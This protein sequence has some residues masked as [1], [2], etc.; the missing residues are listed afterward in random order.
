MFHRLPFSRYSL[1]VTAIYVLAACSACAGQNGDGV[2]A[3]KQSTEQASAGPADPGWPRVFEKDHD[4]VTLYQPQIDEWPNYASISFRAALSVAHGDD[5]KDAKYGV[6]TVKAKTFV[7]HSS[8][9][10]FMTDLDTN[11]HF[12]NVS[13]HEAHRLE[14]MVRKALPKKDYIEVSLERVL[15]CMNENQTKIPHVK[16]N[17]APP[18]IYFSDSPAIMVIFMGPPQFKPVKNTKLMCATNTN[19]DMFLDQN[20]SQYYLL[21]KDSWLVSPDP[22]KGPWAAADNIPSELSQLPDDANWADVIKNIP[23]KYAEHPPKVFTSTKPAELIVTKGTPEYT[24]LSGC[25]LMYVSNPPTPLFLDES[26][27]SYYFLAAGRWFRATSLNGPWAEASTDLPA[28]FAK[29]PADSPVAYVLASVPGTQQAKDAILLASIP[30][31]A[32]VKRGEAKLEVEYDGKPKFADIPDT[33]MKYA[34]NSPEEVILADGKYYCCS[35]GVWFVAADP[36][37]PWAVCVNVPEIIYTIPSTSPVYNVTYVHVYSDTP[38][39]V[40]VGYTD[41]YY[42]EY[43][44][45]TGALMFGAGMIVGAALADDYAYYCPAYFSYGCAA[46]YHYAYGGFYRGCGYYGPYGGAG[47]YAGYNPVT[48][49]FYRGSYRYG[50]RGAASFHQAYNPWTNTYRAHAGATNGYRS[51]GHSAVTRGDEWAKSGHVSG[52]H[53]SAGWARTSTG[54][55]VAGVH[56]AGG[57]WAVKGPQNNVY[58]GHDGNVYK[59]PEGGGWQHWGGDNGWQD[60]HRSAGWNDQGFQNHLN[61]DFQSRSWGND[62]SSRMDQ[63]RGGDFHGFEGGHEGGFGGFGGFRGGGFGGFH[64][65][66]F[67]G[68]HG[69][70]RR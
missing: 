4:R 59:R 19:W 30:H 43:I 39:T 5:E 12:P 10:V 11:V 15:A 41:G 35:K 22:L 24:P 20:T 23:G 36:T 2:G 27:K 68:F 47:H 33:S 70:F 26:D 57:G 67:G 18:P 1:G 40:V 8:S 62:L 44:A 13:E 45:P 3:D 14:D 46:T 60:A 51:W 48:G 6:L 58:A 63:F 42:G 52:P 37:G 17:L 49:A 53:G 38:D 64:G 66:G 32:T 55:S 56:R 28:N 54:K 25:G 16:V 34:T 29:I 61:N 50:P 7:D 9:M 65:G 69:G 31:T 21:D